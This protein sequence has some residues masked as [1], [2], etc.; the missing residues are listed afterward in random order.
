MARARFQG[1]R[2]ILVIVASVVSVSCQLIFSLDNPLAEE[3]CQL[4]EEAPIAEATSSEETVEFENPG[5]LIV[6]RGTACAESDK[7]GREDALKIEQSIQFPAYVNDATIILNGWKVN[8]LSSDHHVLGFGTVIGNIRLEGAKLSWQAAGALSDN[9]F[10]EAYGWC[11]HYTA[12]GWSGNLNLVADNNDGCFTRGGNVN[13]YF[14]SN[15]GQYTALSSFSSFIQNPAFTQPRTVT[16]LPRGYGLTFGNDEHLLQAAYYHDHSEKF[17][18]NGKIYR[19]GTERVNAPLSNPA[20]EADSEFVSWETYSVLKDNDARKNY[21]LGEI[22]SALGGNDIETIEPPFSILPTEDKDDHQ[23]SAVQGTFSEEF[24]VEK[25]PQ[26]YDYAIPVLMGWDIGYCRD[27]EEITQM[28][29]RIEDFNYE[30]AAGG[31]EGKLTYTLA[32][33]FEDENGKPGHY[34]RHNVMI[35]GFLRV[36][37]VV[38][39]RGPDLVPFSPSGTAPSAFCRFEEGG[40][41]LR[42]TVKNQGDTDAGA[43]KTSVAFGGGT[44]TLQTP[45]IAKGGSVDLLFKVPGNCF[46]PDCSFRIIVDSGNQVDEPSGEGNNVASGGCVG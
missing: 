31:A 16:T 15:R 26:R 36:S 21:A 6:I 42:V 13:Y 11:Y 37:N 18:E 2:V 32:S 34:T 14:A 19:K 41:L 17:A 10:K 23:C 33:E 44:V 38:G 25:I 45:P 3:L 8:Y 46:S 40:K 35:L 20:S 5:T 22:V 9:D 24:T 29:V 39:S 27:D 30:K 12:L 43:S 7:S 1:L 4:I 28:G